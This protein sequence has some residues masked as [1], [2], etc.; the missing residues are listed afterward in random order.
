MPFGMSL[1]YRSP[2]LMS[3]FNWSSVVYRRIRFDWTYHGTSYWSDRTLV[4][5]AINERHS[6]CRIDSDSRQRPNKDGNGL[7]SL[8]LV[9][10]M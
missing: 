1:I 5:C 3:S 10:G 6:L 9:C 4:I 8:V 7:W 2:V